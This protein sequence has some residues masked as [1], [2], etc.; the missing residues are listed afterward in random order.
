MY[1]GKIVVAYGLK[2]Q[3]GA[4]GVRIESELNVEGKPRKHVQTHWVTNAKGETTYETKDGKKH[5]LAGF[6]N[7]NALCYLLLNK[8]LNQ[9]IT[10][11]RNIK[12][13]DKLELV[14]VLTELSD[15]P[16]ALG[17]LKIR[18]NKQVK[19]GDEYIDSNEEQFINEVDYVFD[20]DGLTHIERKNGKTEPEFIFKW[21]ETNVGEGKF[22]DKYKEVKSSNKSSTGATID[23]A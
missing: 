6:N 17:I 18:Q 16:I 3:R 9:V 11:D 21:K 4:M 10:E 2:S 8:G 23:F 22:K 19:S 20:A 15:K 12:I 14:P 7:V 5:Q 13:G 1:V